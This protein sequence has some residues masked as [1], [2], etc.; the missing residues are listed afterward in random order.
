MTVLRTILIGG[1]LAVLQTT[2]ISGLQIGGAQPD[3]V[4][5]ILTAYAS[6]AGVQRGQ[7]AG[8]VVGLIEDGLSV[9]PPGFYAVVRLLHSALAGTVRAS[10]AEEV[11]VF[12]MVM[13]TIAFTVKTTAVL[14]T[15]SILRLEA[16]A[17]RVFSTTTLVE[18]AM[19]IILAPLVFWLCRKVFPA[20]NRRAF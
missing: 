10:I 2:W 6:V 18:G 5:I 3:L 19:T 13:T 1:I 9:S 4:L 14:V 17:P 8:F 20:S 7:V 16:V 11:L 15:A 12:P